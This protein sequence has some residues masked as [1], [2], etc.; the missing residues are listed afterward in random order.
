MAEEDSAEALQLALFSLHPPCAITDA[1]FLPHFG[2]GQDLLVVARGPLLQFGA[3]AERA[4]FGPS[5]STCSSP[6][7]RASSLC[8]IR[9]IGSRGCSW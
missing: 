5:R 4:R 3:V 2:A 6:R 7:R 8:G 9:L 1:A